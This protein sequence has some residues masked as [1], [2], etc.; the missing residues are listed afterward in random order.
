MTLLNAPRRVLAALVTTGLI[1]SACATGPTEPPE[2]ARVGPMVSAANPLAAEAGMAVLKR[3]GS[4]VDAAVAIQAV[5]GLVEPQSSGLGG[6]A[7]MMRYSAVTGELTAY[8]GRETAPASATPE[9]FYENGELLSYRNAILSGRSTGAP[10][11]IPMLALAHRDHGNLPWAELF[12]DAERLATEGFTVSPR[13]AGMIASEAPQASSPDARRYFTMP[14]GSRVQA[15]DTLSNPAY[16]D[17]LR[18]IAAG[19]AEAF[20]T[21]PIAEAIVAAVQEGPRPGGLTTRDIAAYQ[22]LERGALC[23]P[24]RVYVVCV[25][26]PPSSGVGVLQFLA[27]AEHAPELEYGPQD[28]RAWIA[29]GRLQRAMYADRDQY[30]GDPGFVGVPVQ[31]MLDGRYTEG[32]A[33]LALSS[34]GPIPAGSPPGGIFTGPDATQEPAGTSHF[35]VV[36]ARGNAVSMTTTVESIFGS[37]RMAAGFFL[38]NQLTDFSFTPTDASGAPVANAVAAGKRPRSSMSPI[39]VIDNRNRLVTAIGSPGGNAILAYN[40]KALVGMLIWDLPIQDAIDLPNLVARGETVGADTAM[41]SMEM[42]AALAEAGLALR[43]NDAENSGLHGVL[44]RDGRWTGGADRRRE[45]VVLDALSPLPSIPA[46]EIEAPVG[47]EV[48]PTNR[49]GAR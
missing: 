7:F 14:D 23:R 38:N 39:I 19:G 24:F 25:P 29:F 41:F 18:R 11:A 1:L 30:V 16:A 27:M 22:P 42:E 45:G 43:P 37:G 35:V 2:Y 46:P 3:G 31:G 21:G 48:I 34:R 28:A 20:Q 15:G 10:G 32:R 26:P 6:G 33:E 17:T 5:L 40:L 4:A 8:D 47:E 9:L 13:L 36:D 44:W 49:A 12:V